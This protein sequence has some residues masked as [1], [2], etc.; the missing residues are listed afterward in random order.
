MKKKKSYQFLSFLF[1]QFCTKSSK[2]FKYLAIHK[3][4]ATGICLWSSHTRLSG[5]NPQSIGREVLTN[6]QV[7]QTKFWKFT[8]WNFQWYFTE[9]SSYICRTSPTG[10]SKRCLDAVGECLTSEHLKKPKGSELR[11][12]RTG[13]IKPWKDEQILMLKPVDSKNSPRFLQHPNVWKCFNQGTLGK[14]QV[15]AELPVGNK[16][17]QQLQPLLQGFLL[18]PQPWSCWHWHRCWHRWHHRLQHLPPSKLAGFDSLVTW[19]SDTGS[20]HSQLRVFGWLWGFRRDIPR[21]GM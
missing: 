10:A 12:K 16:H 7:L 21:V 14:H 17:L 19:P 8:T 3:S 9:I 18:M 6:V 2:K 5:Q 1:L 11:W 4:T 15:L 13:S 20:S